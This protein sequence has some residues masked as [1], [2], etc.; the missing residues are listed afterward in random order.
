VSWLLQLLITRRDRL[1]LLAWASLLILFGVLFVAIFAPW[2]APYELAHVNVT[3]QLE[4]PSMAHWLGTDE[5]GT[6][7]LTKI[8]FGARV[9][10]LVGL[11][12]VAICSTV[13]V[14]LG[15]ISGYFGGVVDEV[16]MR[17]TEILMAFPGI[18]LAI[19][20][21][22]ITQ[23]PS[24]LAVIGALSVSG[25]AGYARLVRGQVLSERERAY[26]EAS[27]AL[28]FPTRR[29]LFREIIPNIMAPVIVQATF[30]VAGAILAEASLSFLG[31]GPQNLPSWG[32]LLD[33]GATYFLLTPHLAIFPGL[34]IM[35]TVLSINFV[36]D[37]L[38][39][40]LD[41]RAM[42]RAK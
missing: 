28:G 6:D 34:A 19:L 8:I 4:A 1:N 17:I 32:A 5:N 35:I 7:V 38:R 41:P 27:T 25:W 14:T 3:R 42:T 36:G 23:R 22:F 16:I 29:I 31:L 12:T 26:V 11:S 13:G 10:V 30:G 21:I 15:A 20:L 24:L 9:A 37:G 40:I 2:I 33:Q 18:L 39:D